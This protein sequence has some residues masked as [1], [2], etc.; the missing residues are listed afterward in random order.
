MMTKKITDILEQKNRA[1]SPEELG[2]AL[3]LKD[4]EKA[5]LAM[6]MAELVQKGV[7]QRTKKGRY[8]LLAEDKIFA[9]TIQLTD[10]NFGFFLY[11]EPGHE[12]VF[13][14]G[15][16]LHG[17]MNGDRV[18]VKIIQEK[19]GDQKAEGI[20]LKVLDRRTTTVIGILQVNKDHAFLIPYDRKVRT[21]IY[22][23]VKENKLTKQ[24]EGMVAEVT[25][26]KWPTEGKNPEGRVVDIL[27]RVD[28]PGLDVEMVIR[29]F[30]LPSEFP[31]EVLDE[32]KALQEE[33]M[34]EEF[35]HRK[36]L[37]DLLTFTIDGADAKDIDDAVSIETTQDGYRLGVHIADVS[38][39]VKEYSALDKEA[40]R[41][42]TS[43]YLVSKVLPMLP[44]ELSNDLCSLNPGEDKLAMS[45]MIELNRKGETLSHE[46][47]PSVIRSSYRLV[48]DDVSDLL[49]GKEVPA[50]KEIEAPLQAMGELSK[51]LTEKRRLRGAIDFGIAESYFELDENGWPIDMKFRERR[52]ANRLIEEFMILTNE[53]VSEHFYWIEVPFLYRTHEKP[54]AE[55]LMEFNTFIHN[56]GFHLKGRLENIHPSALNLLIDQV[57]GSPQEH[58]INKMM[59]RSLKQ[60][61]YTNYFEGHFGL[62]STYYSH[63]T[64]PIRRYPDLQ[65]HRIIKDQLAGKM[66]KR[67]R[68]HYDSILEAVSEQSNMTERRAD[69]AERKIDDIKAAQFMSDRI[70]EEFDAVISGLTGF[71][72]FVE[73][74]N[75]AEGLI[76]LSSLDEF[77]QFDKEKYILTG[78]KGTKLELGR[79]LRVKL[80]SVNTQRGEINFELMR[81]GHE[82]TRNGS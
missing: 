10:R 70:G 80:V 57:E 35:E 23:D 67:R 41:R 81:Y 15:S 11:D 19:V 21:D 45:V 43:V 2:K 25:I 77:F 37:R 1:M 18:L 71:G 6:A 78:N 60:A 14:H 82:T 54:S 29:T 5:A 13:I 32:A 49:E 3:N 55:K 50:L 62:A 26:I 24:H 65:I 64:A 7:I 68:E 58:L 69:D 52:I 59:L 51:L 48:Y 28:D 74:D 40:F 63:F 36:D 66:T 75:S 56:F 44:K 27:G 46:I 8:R 17:A 20:V 34:Q 73:L 53:V 61:K 33:P 9:G 79:A 76:P 22:L 30:D 16:A 42:G 31:Q 72:I 4:N 39:Y 38:H 12:D 47:F